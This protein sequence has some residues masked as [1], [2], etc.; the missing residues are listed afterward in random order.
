MLPIVRRTAGLRYLGTQESADG[1]LADLQTLVP[2]STWTVVSAD[3][4]TL[5]LHEVGEWSEQDHMMQAGWWMVVIADLGFVDYLDDA[6]FQLRYHP[7]AI[8]E[9]G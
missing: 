8:P 9:E 7:T 1:I 6:R 4:D 5:R 3:A 2:R